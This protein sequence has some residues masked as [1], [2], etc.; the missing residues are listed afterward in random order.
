MLV[1]GRLLGEGVDPIYA[2]L[3]S[4]NP[5]Q[6][7]QSGLKCLDILRLQADERSIP[8]RRNHMNLPSKQ[9]H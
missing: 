1:S 8:P 2:P 4:T 6:S 3:V 7:D 9:V 5:C